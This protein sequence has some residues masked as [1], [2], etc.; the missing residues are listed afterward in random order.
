VSAVQ[1][2]GPSW[3]KNLGLAKRMQMQM[4]DHMP[5]VLAFCPGR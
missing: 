1:R 5:R 4:R 2:S 3:S